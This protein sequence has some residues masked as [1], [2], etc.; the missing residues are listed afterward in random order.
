MDDKLETNKDETLE[1]PQ[2]PSPQPEPQPQTQP[3]SEIDPDPY[4][5]KNPYLNT[6]SP[7][8]SPSVPGRKRG[9]KKLLLLA[10]L[11]ILALVLFGPFKALTGDKKLTPT[12]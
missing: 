6:S 7:Y 4:P 9:P 5:D 2:E 12:P 3:E 8:T 10:G 1:T 11:V